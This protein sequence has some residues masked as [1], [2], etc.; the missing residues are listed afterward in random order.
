MWPKIAAIKLN[1]SNDK[2]KAM[3]ESV[4]LDLPVAAFLP[5]IVP[6]MS[7]EQ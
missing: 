2:T 6:L 1:Q 5:K 4:F 7:F 3:V